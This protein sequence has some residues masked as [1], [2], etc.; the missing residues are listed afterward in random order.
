M[1]TQDLKDAECDLDNPTF[2]WD[3]NSYPCIP[4]TDTQVFKVNRGYEV[5]KTLAMTVRNFNPDGTFVFT[6][7]NIP[8]SQDDITYQGEPFRIEEVSGNVIRAAFNLL[9]VS[10]TRTN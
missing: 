6:N 9:C 2:E 1:M 5:V 7:N 3:G 10:T 8:E 4:G